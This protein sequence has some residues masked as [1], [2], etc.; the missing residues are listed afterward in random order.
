MF[1]E[2]LVDI[3]PEDE[4]LAAQLV[5][6][7]YERQAGRI[8]IEEKKTMKIRLGRSPDDSDGLALA[9]MDKQL[10]PGVAGVKRVLW[11]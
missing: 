7:R 11:G 5:E 1:R 8:K 10:V 2:G 6:L 3:D 4:D 9:S